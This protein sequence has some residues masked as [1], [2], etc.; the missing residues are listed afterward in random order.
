M[1][2]D[3][4]HLPPWKYQPAHGAIHVDSR[5]SPDDLIDVVQMPRGGADRPA[6]QAVRLALLQQHGR[7]QRGAAA[8]FQ[9]GVLGRHPAA[10]GE[11]VIVLPIFPVSLVLFGIDDREVLCDPDAQPMTLDAALDHRRPAHQ[12][13][14]RE[15]LVHDDLHRAQHPLVLTFRIDYP[16]ALRRHRARR[17]KYGLH[18][19]PAVVHEL[20]QALAIR[21]QVGDGPRSHPGIHGGL[22]NR[23]SDFHDQPRI[24]GLGNEIFRAETQVLDAAVGRGHHIALLLARQLGDGVDGGDFHLPGDG[25]GPH[26]Q[27]TAKN[28]GKTQDIVDLVGIV[29]APGRDD[30]VVAHRSYLLRQ[31]FRRRIGEGEYQGSRRHPLHHVLSEHASG[32]QA[33]EHVRAADDL[34]QSPG[35][36]G[37]REAGLFGIHQLLPPFVN[38]TGKIGQPDVL[39]R[40]S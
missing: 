24:E 26:V 37:L 20:Q 40:Q 13:G 36:G 29:A 21:V 30:G 10:L 27:R 18:Q 5:G 31:D 7:D 12:D 25:R 14:R 28:E 39:A 33:E 8:H 22:G 17:R 35:V 4:E 38:D 32:G 2:I 34:R 11:L 16:A 6:D 15:L 3:D 1:S 19:G 9:L 23:R